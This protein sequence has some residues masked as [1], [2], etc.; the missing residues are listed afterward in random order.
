M[1]RWRIIAS[2]DQVLDLY[3]RKKHL[4]VEGAEENMVQ[5]KIP[6][7]ES[8]WREVFNENSFQ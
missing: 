8:C 5:A 6:C 1:N 3:S 7:G 4:D 2:S